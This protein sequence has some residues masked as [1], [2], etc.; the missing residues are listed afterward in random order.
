MLPELTGLTQNTEQRADSS[1]NCNPCSSFR[2]N[3]M[4]SP[5]QELVHQALVDVLKISLPSLNVPILRS[6]ASSANFV[7]SQLIAFLGC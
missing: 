4:S 5:S 6:R 1:D 7:P 3:R 2:A